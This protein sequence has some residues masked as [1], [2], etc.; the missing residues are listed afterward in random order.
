MKNLHRIVPATLCLATALILTTTGGLAWAFQKADDKAPPAAQNTPAKTPPAAAGPAATAPG[1]PTG[2]AAPRGVPVVKPATPVDPKLFIVKA[3]PEEL[4]LGEIPTNDSGRGTLY[5][6]NTGDKPMTVVSSRASCG[7]TS[8][9]LL[10]NTVIP[11]GEKAE[12]QVQMNGGMNPGPLHGKTVTFVVEGQPDLVVRLKATAVSYVVTE[13]KALDPAIHEDGKLVFKSVDGKPFKIMSMQPPVITEFPKEAQTEITINFSWAKFR[14]IGISRKATFFLDHPKCQQVAI[15]VNFPAEEIAADAAKKAEARRASG[16]AINQPAAANRAN[17]GAKPAASDPDATLRQLINDKKNDEVMAKITGGLDVNYK[18]NAGISL[19]S[20]A[21]KAGNS[22]LV[23]SLVATKKVNIDGTDNVGRTALMHAA[24][25][26]NAQTVQAL[27]GSGAS[28][29]VR[30]TLG[31]TALSWA[32]G[33]GDAASVR[34]LIDAGA[35][36]EVVGAVT[37]WTPLIWASGFGDPES[38]APLIKAHAN[39]EAAD[40]LQGATPLIHAARTGKVEA[41]KA[42]VKAGAKLEYADRNGFTALLIAAGTS[43]GT[44]DKVQALIDAKCNIKA[45]DN[46]GFNALELAEKRTDIRAAEVVKV[47]EPLL[48]DEPRN[49]AAASDAKPVVKPTGDAVKTEA[50]KAAGH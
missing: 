32:A 2:A 20:M 13:P 19:L 6:H 21:A 31:Q 23:K 37:G 39:L 27:L 34:E 36:V 49:A 40:T 10:P 3:E 46:R 24:T 43:G 11:A 17:S 41:V 5:L 35:D 12:V 48:K 7:C 28:V 18:D 42:L 38:I 30:D 4:D 25:S 44:A 50:P 47:L 45:R 33:L 16:A 15:L 22:D 9:K 8:L 29:A 14:E 1:L 26:K